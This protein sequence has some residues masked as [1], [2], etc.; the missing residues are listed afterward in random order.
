MGTYAYQCPPPVDAALVKLRRRSVL[1]ED[2][3]SHGQKGPDACVGCCGDVEAG[4][5][6]RLSVLVDQ[7]IED[8]RVLRLEAVRGSVEASGV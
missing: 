4:V 6:Q 1:D 7:T 5:L 8:G 3:I 2:T